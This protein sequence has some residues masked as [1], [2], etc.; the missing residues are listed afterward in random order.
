MAADILESPVAKQMIAVDVAVPTLSDPFARPTATAALVE[1]YT[2]QPAPPATGVTPAHP[3]ISTT[4]AHAPTIDTISLFIPVLLLVIRAT[5][6]I[7]PARLIERARL[8][9]LAESDSNQPPSRCP[10]SACPRHAANLDF[11]CLGRLKI[12]HRMA[13]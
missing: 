1:V 3:V 10:L 6:A 5:G 8:P 2:I 9:C 12:F 7:P 13:E 4:A 11:L